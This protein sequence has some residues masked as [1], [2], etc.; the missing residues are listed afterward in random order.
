MKLKVSYNQK[1]KIELKNGYRIGLLTPKKLAEMSNK[2]IVMLYL[3]DAQ[4]IV[5]ILS[6]FT[7][8]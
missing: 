2:P 3:E 7:K 5:T 6:R 8:I 1:C 4:K